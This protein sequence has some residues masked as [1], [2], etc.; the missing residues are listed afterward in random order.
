MDNFFQELARNAVELHFQ[1]TEQFVTALLP[2]TITVILHGFG[3]RLAAWTLTRFE[4]RLHHGFRAGPHPFLM[5]AIV[6]IMLATHYLEVCSWAAFYYMADMLPNYKT[7]MNFSIDAY[8][9]LGA[10]NITLHGRWQGLGG[11]EAMTAMLMFGWSTA[12]L[13][14]VAL[15]VHNID[16]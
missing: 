7:A 12:I 14:A 6:A 5:V 4:V 16:E 11:F 9:T 8:T 1:Y 13:A 15:K 2:M 10:S 3:M